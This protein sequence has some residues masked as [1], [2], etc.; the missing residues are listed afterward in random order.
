MFLLFRFWRAFAIL[1][2]SAQS[3][4]NTV[5][6]IRLKWLNPCD[7]PHNISHVKVKLGRIWQPLQFKMKVPRLVP[8]LLKNC[9]YLLRGTKYCISKRAVWN[10]IP[11]FKFIFCTWNKILKCSHNHYR[12][13]S[14]KSINWQRSLWSINFVKGKKYTQKQ[15]FTKCLSLREG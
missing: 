7:R 1:A 11:D 12:P 13:N 8:R 15:I 9:S 6:R 10:S 5:R 2:N 14:K 3:W 4:Q